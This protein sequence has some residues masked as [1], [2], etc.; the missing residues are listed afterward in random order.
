MVTAVDK[1]LSSVHV[2]HFVKFEPFSLSRSAEIYVSICVTNGSD[3]MRIAD[4]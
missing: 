2:Q 4:T 1:A 3:S